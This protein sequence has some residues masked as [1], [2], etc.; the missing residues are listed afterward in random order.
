VPASF[1]AGNIEVAVFSSGEAPF[2]ARWLRSR[3]EMELSRNLGTMGDLMAELRAEIKQLPVDQEQRARLLN[4]V[5]ESDVLDILRDEGKQAAL[6]RARALV[7]S[8]IEDS[9]A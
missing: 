6:Q 9:Q 2:F 1:R 8:L 4:S 3:L 7:A 5:L